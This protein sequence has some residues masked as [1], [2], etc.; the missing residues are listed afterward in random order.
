MTGTGAIGLMAIFLVDFLSLFYVS[1]LRDDRLTA[2]VG[3]AT[4][5]M[6]VAIS[7]NIGSMIAGS[8]MVARRRGAWMRRARGASPPPRWRSPR[9][10]ALS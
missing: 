3:Y 5:I 2:G 10:W 4:T 9:L 7:V 1:M 8:A 6:F